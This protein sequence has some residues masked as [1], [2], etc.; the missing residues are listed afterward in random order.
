MVKLVMCCLW[1]GLHSKYWKKQI[2]TDYNKWSRKSK[3]K[4]F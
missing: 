4:K 2:S 3:R 1:F